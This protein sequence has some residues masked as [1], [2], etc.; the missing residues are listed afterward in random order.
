MGSTPKLQFLF[1]MFK[2]SSFR[3]DQEADLCQ[4]G[5]WFGEQL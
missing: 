3:S 5:R 2:W 1:K 4:D